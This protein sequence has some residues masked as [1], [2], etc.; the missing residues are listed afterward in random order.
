[1]TLINLTEEYIRTNKP[2]FYERIRMACGFDLYWASSLLNIEEHFKEFPPLKKDRFFSQKSAYVLMYNLEIKRMDPDDFDDEDGVSLEFG[3][4][5]GLLQV[6]HFILRDETC[7]KLGSWMAGKSPQYLSDREEFGF[8]KKSFVVIPKIYLQYRHD[9]KR[10]WLAIKSL[11]RDRK[12][13]LIRESLRD[14]ISRL[15]PRL[16]VLQ[17]ESI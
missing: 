6:P 9:E 7:E 16:G 10:G 8:N 13:E 14:K 17:P 5:G 2:P 3:L 1:M 15:S 4:D 12:P 11:N